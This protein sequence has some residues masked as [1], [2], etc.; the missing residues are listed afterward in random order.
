MSGCADDD[1]LPII[2][3]RGRFLKV[4]LEGPS[5]HSRAKT[6]LFRD[7]NS[8]RFVVEFSNLEVKD[9]GEYSIYIT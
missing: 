9:V 8:L 4:A 7:R 3:S 2:K 1:G 6:T 5:G